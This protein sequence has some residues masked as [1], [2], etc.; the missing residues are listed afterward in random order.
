MALLLRSRSSAMTSSIL[1]SGARHVALRQQ[2]LDD[3]GRAVPA[4]PA[5]EKRISSSASTA[6]TAASP[7]PAAT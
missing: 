1:R 6:R 2:C 7:P 5:L 4:C 3:F